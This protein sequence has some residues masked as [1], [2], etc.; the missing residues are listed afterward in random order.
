MQEE[1]GNKEKGNTLQLLRYLLEFLGLR[2]GAFFLGFFSVSIFSNAYFFG[3]TEGERG[4]TVSVGRGLYS[5]IQ[6][7]A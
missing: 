4:G 2:R 7:G 3:L 6:T 5:C 1:E